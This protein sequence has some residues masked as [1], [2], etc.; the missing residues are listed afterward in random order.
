MQDC[1]Y[2]SM[3]WYLQEDLVHLL[4]AGTLHFSRKDGRVVTGEMVEN[5]T[6]ALGTRH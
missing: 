3:A 6:V 5:K 4:P 1:W 2:V